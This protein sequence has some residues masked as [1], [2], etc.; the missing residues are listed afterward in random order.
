MAHANIDLSKVEHS[1]VLAALRYWQRHAG[2]GRM[3]LEF[4]DIATDGGT[5]A[6]ATAEQID[7]LCER[8]NSP[9]AD[10]EPDDGQ[11]RTRTVSVS[12]DVTADSDE[13]AIGYALDDLNDETLEMTWRVEGRPV[14]YK[15]G[16]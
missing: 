4:E 11:P 1:T 2:P 8:I 6:A 5:H 7:A 10:P 16:G 9:D 14:E 12:L 15:H 13:Q 3:S